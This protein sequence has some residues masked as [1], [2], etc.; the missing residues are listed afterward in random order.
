[1]AEAR[2]KDNWHHTA[3]MLALLANAHRD[4][5]KT[6]PFKPDDFNPFANKEEPIRLKDNQEAFALLKHVFVDRKEAH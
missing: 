3:A 4:P 2:S 6:G 1:M 5:K